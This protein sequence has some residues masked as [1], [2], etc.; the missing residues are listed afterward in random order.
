M[1][2][3]W[4]NS[5]LPFFVFQSDYNDECVFNET[6][7]SNNYNVYT[8]H[9]YSNKKHTTYVA[10]N[11]SGKPRQVRRKAGAGTG[12]LAACAN[13]LTEPV[14]SDQVDKLEQRKR[15]LYAD[16]Q[17]HQLRHNHLCPPPYHETTR[18]KRSRHCRKKKRAPTGAVDVTHKDHQ[19]GA[20]KKAPAQDEADCKEK[21]CKKKKSAQSSKRS[22]TAKSA[23]SESAEEDEATTAAAGAEE[24]ADD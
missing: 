22:K 7:E 6:I 19:A 13:A 2:A 12:K 24:G 21:K 16:H 18:R 10:L 15:S 20:K 14:S 5:H 17:A 23:Q 1:R 9:K 4:R 11:S 8:S 3:N